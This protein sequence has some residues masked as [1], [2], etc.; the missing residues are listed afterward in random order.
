MLWNWVNI[1]KEWWDIV[2]KLFSKRGIYFQFLDI[3]GYIYFYEEDIMYYNLKTTNIIENKY[4]SIIL[5]IEYKQFQNEKINFI[6]F[7]I[8]TSKNLLLWK[9]D[10]NI[11]SCRY[12]VQ[13]IK[14][15]RRYKSNKHKISS[16]FNLYILI[17]DSSFS[18]EKEARYR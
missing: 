3:N 6:H 17:K 4:H 18:L 5:N 7:N 15:Q 16:I 12:F 1:F 14:E 9:W 11:L 8:K 13:N 10:G 2:R